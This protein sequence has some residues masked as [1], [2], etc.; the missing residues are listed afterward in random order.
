M[1]RLLPLIA[2]L[3]LV[4][5]TGTVAHAASDTEGKTTLQQTIRGTNGP[6]YDPQG[7]GPGLRS[8]VR[9]RGNAK[10]QSGRERRRGSL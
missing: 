10:P 3:G 7:L 5:A 6:G 2:A 8:V 9:E 4:V 1:R